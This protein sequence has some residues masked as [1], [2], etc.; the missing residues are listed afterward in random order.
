MAWRS[1]PVRDGWHYSGGSQVGTRGQPRGRCARPHRKTRMSQ[2]HDDK[3]VY[4]EPLGEDGRVTRARQQRKKRRMRI[5]AAAQRV[6]AAKGYHGASVSD[7]I[8]AAGA[9]RGTFYLYFDGKRAIFDELLDELF[10]KLRACV[11]PVDVSSGAPTAVAQLRDNVRRAVETVVHNQDL[12]RILYRTGQGIDP[13]F[14]RKV[15]EFNEAI[16]DLIRRALRKGM[17]IR[18]VRPLDSEL[19]AHCIY[20]SVKESVFYM[21]ESKR[22]DEESILPIVEEVLR[23]NLRGVLQ[24]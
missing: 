22:L 1:A 13:E 18:V 2:D 21:L 4:G 17:E 16:L 15:E 8:E 5:V 9:S 23:H 10:G 20:G 19:V 7:V 11:H 12:V 14:D 3:K 24:S 6:F